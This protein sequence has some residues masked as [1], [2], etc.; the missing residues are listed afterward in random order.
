ML[1]DASRPDS[2]AQ[3]GVSRI[4]NI[5]GYLGRGNK[6]IDIK[7]G[8]VV[9]VNER[10]QKSSQA[11]LVVDVDM[12]RCWVSDL[13]LYDQVKSSIDV[14]AEELRELAISYWQSLVRLE[15]YEWRA[16]RRP[17]IMITYDIVPSSITVLD[18]AK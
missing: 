18:P 4:N 6:I 7:D 5:Y 14:G 8:S 2:L 15:H 10:I 17:E 11:L 9:T 16:V 12:A 1:L 13:D 3:V